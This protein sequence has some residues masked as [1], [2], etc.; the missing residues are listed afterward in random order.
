MLSINHNQFIGD[1]S[2]SFLGAGAPVF[3]STSK[4]FNQKIDVSAVSNNGSDDETTNDNAEEEYDPHYE[5]I[6][7]L[8]EAIMVS[9]GEED[10]SVL[11]NERAKL[12]RYDGD[13]KEWK[14]R[15]VGQLKILHH[16]QNSK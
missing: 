8:P 3:G 11:F 9:T 7:P 2:F 16:P 15:G 10:E 1:N 13:N 12:Y 6:V 5:P 14:E 4:N